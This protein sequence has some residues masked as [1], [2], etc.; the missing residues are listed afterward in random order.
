[1]GI[2]RRRHAERPTPPTPPPGPFRLPPPVSVELATP[3]REL[4]IDRVRQSVFDTYVTRPR[5]RRFTG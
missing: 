5:P 2:L 3:V 4:F 1:M